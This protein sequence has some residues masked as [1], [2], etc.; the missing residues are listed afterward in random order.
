M[1]AAEI[2]TAGCRNLPEFDFVKEEDDA[3]SA[4]F[5]LKVAATVNQQWHLD[6]K[7]A[8]SSQT[9]SMRNYEGIELLLSSSCTISRNYLRIILTNYSTLIAWYGNKVYAHQRTVTGKQEPQ[10]FR[11]AV[12]VG[13]LLYKCEIRKEQYMESFP[14][15]LGQ[16]LKISDELH[17]LYC[18]VERDNQIPPQL[19]GSS[20]YQ[21]ASEMPISA[22]AQLG[23]RM[24]PYIT[25]AR[26]YQ[27]KGKEYSGLAAWYLQQ[28]YDIA[29]KIGTELAR[30][31]RFDEYEKAQLFLGYLAALPRRESKEQPH[32]TKGE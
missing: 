21:L 29:E 19:V 10:L 23:I 5:P 16:I 18:T 4:P 27:K 15:L 20:F 31:N 24:N 2:W 7:T 13:L 1:T 14:Y 3:L 8:V 25:W 12:I 28:Y 22:F 32:T 6:G 9:K 17:A 11:A 26:A 30:K